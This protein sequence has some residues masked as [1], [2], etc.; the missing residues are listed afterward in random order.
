MKS[1]VPCLVLLFSCFLIGCQTSQGISEPNQ[2]VNVTREAVSE[3]PETLNPECTQPTKV[4]LT[5]EPIAQNKAKFSLTGLQSGEFLTFVVIAKASEFYDE[6]NQTTLSYN[7]QHE[8]IM[9]SPVDEDGTFS[10]EVGGLDPLP[11]S[12]EN[13]WIVKVIHAQGVNCQEF[14]LP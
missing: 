13:R 5:I 14:S 3:I 1:F 11:N 10:Y 9:Q 12:T 2:T 8:I 4:G 7:G 6:Q